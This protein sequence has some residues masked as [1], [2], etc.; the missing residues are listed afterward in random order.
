MPAVWVGFKLMP[1]DFLDATAVD[2]Y[3]ARYSRASRSS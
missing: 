3:R 1:R 2:C